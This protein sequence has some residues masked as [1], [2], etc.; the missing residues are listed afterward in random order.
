MIMVELYKKVNKQF[1]MV[2]QINLRGYYSLRSAIL[3][4]KQIITKR[5]EINRLV[6]VDAFKVFNSNKTP[7]TPILMR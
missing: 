4:V 2:E 3:K 6:N 1:I 7:I 5:N